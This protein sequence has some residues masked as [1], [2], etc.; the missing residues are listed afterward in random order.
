MEDSFLPLI[1]REMPGLP[2]VDCSEGIGLIED[3]EG[4]NP[5]IWLNTENAG[6]MVDNM[7]NRLMELMPEHA[8]QIRRN[9]DAYI[10]RLAALH[11]ELAQRLGGLPH[12]DVVTFHEAYPYFAA[13]FGLH[14]VASVTAE[15]D[16]APSPRMIAETVEKIKTY[17]LCP[18]FAEPGVTADALEVIARETG[19][20]VYEL[21]PITDGDGSPEDYEAAMRRN[22]GT[23]AQ[24]LGAP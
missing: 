23:L 15:P 6:R 19:Q 12:R 18:L 17:P 5:H 14:V 4:P 13:E 1:R 16:E 20:P 24:A 3:D 8:E 10:D 7:A 22:A 11:E 21:D 9:A 2:I